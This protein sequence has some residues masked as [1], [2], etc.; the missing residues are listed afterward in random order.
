MSWSIPKVGLVI[1]VIPLLSMLVIFPF[2]PEMIPTHFGFALSPDTFSSKWSAIGITAL[3]LIPLSSIVSF[4]I[5]YY[6]VPGLIRITEEDD[7]PPIN[8]K[9]LELIIPIAATCFL[10]AYVVSTCLLLNNL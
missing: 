1:A 9:H 4:I 8:P 7:H 2:L 5:L 6:A 10:I 3:F